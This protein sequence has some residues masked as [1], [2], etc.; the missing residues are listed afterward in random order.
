MHTADA[1]QIEA[2]SGERCSSSGALSGLTR[3]K[4][5]CLRISSMND[6]M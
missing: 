6:E 5:S 3:G 2:N 4:P 1:G